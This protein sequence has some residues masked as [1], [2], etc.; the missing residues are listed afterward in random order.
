VCDL[1]DN[2]N[3]LYYYIFST[4]KSE[5]GG[6]VIKNSQPLPPQVLWGNQLDNLRRCGYPLPAYDEVA[7]EI[8]FSEE[9]KLKLGPAL[10]VD[11]ETPIAKQCQLLGIE[12]YLNLTHHKDWG[13]KPRSRWGWIYEVDD[14]RKV[15]GR[16]PNNVIEEFNRN[17]RRGLMTVEGLALYREN[18]DLLLNHFVDL[19][20][21]R[22]FRTED[23]CVPHLHLNGNELNRPSLVY[24]PLGADNPKW[25]SASCVRE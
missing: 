1:F 18:P 17:K 24:G 15:L 13:M 20:G 2:I 4:I 19:I 23:V 14:G 10:L 8:P 16:S 25:G 12:N 21:S 22:Y 5:Y 7:F 9:L 3:N 6:N 11:Y